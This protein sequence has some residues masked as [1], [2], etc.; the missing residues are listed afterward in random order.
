MKKLLI[1]A[2]IIAALSGSALAQL[3]VASGIVSGTGTSQVISVSPTGIPLPFY[4][5]L[6]W[7]TV[8]APVG[9]CGIA[10]DSSITGSPTPEAGVPAQ[11]CATT[12]SATSASAVVSNLIAVHWSM[13]GAGSIFYTVTESLT[14]PASGS[15]TITA[16]NAGTGITGGGV[17]GS[18]NVAIAASYRLPQS[19]S[20]GQVAT[21]DSTTSAWDTCASAAGTIT[22]V[23]A[24]TGLSGGGV[25]GAVTLNLNAT[26]TTCSSQVLTAINSSAVG[27]CTPLT[28]SYL[29]LSAMGT[30]TGGTWQGSVIGSTYGGT[31]VNNT[32]T[33]T[34]GSVNVN[35]ATLGTGLVYNTTGTGALT[36][37]NAA[38]VVTVIGSTAVTNATN[39]ANIATT[40]GSASGATFYPVFVGSNS[41]SNQGV[42]TTAALNFVPST[43]VLSATSFSGAGTNLTGTAS[44]LSIGGNAA[45]ATTA[46]NATNVA[47]TGGSASSSTFYPT[48][49]SSNSSGNYPIITTGALSFVPST[50]ALSATSFSG[51]G[52]GLTGT[53][54][55][56]SIGGNA[57]TA[58]GINGNGTA[59]QVWGMNSGGSAQ[60]WQNQSGTPLG[61]STQ[62]PIMNSGATAYAPQTISQDASLSNSGVLTV[63]GINAVPLCTGFTPTAGQALE[64]STSLSPNPCYTAATPGG[65]LSG[66]LGEPYVAPNSG[67]S[68]VTSPLYLDVSQV[69]GATGDAI[70][71]GATAYLITAGGGTGDTRAIPTESLTSLTQLTD[72]LAPPAVA[73]TGTSPCSSGT[74]QAKIVYTYSSAGCGGE[75]TQ[76]ASQETLVSS[77]STSQKITVTAPTYTGS[78]TGWNVYMAIASGSAP[79]SWTETKCNTTALT[80]GVNYDITAACSGAAVNLKNYNLAWILPVDGAWTCTMTAGTSDCIDIGNHTDIEGSVTGS[81]SIFKIQAASTTNVASSGVTGVPGALFGTSPNPKLGVGSIYIRVVGLSVWDQQTAAVV[82]STIRIGNTSDSSVVRDVSEINAYQSSNSGGPYGDGGCGIWA[83]GVGYADWQNIHVDGNNSTGEYGFCLGAPGAGQTVLNIDS[84]VSV[85]TSGPN[86]YYYGGQNDLNIQ[87]LTEEGETAVSGCSNVMNDF[88]AG[89]TQNGAVHIGT[90]KIGANCTSSTATAIKLESNAN[91]IDIDRISIGGATGMTCITNNVSG[92]PTTPLTQSQCDSVAT[93]PAA[94]YHISRTPPIFAAGLSSGK[95][96][97][98]NGNPFLTSANT[99]SAVDSVTI[100]NAATANPATVTITASGSDANINLN[101]VSTGTGPVQ[102]NGSSGANTALSNL[103]SVAVNLALSPGTDNSIALDDLSHRYTNA[104]LAGVFGWTNGSGTADTGL[105]RDSAGVVDVGNGTASDTSGTLQATKLTLTGSTHG[106]TIPA[107][108][109]VSGAAGKVIFASD[110]TNGYAEANENNTGLSRICTAANG[111]CPSGTTTNALTGAVSG[112]ASPGTTFNGSAAV[113]FDY[114]TLGAAPTASPTFTGTVTTPLTTAGL[115]TTTSGGVLGSEAQATAAQ[116]GTGISTSSSTGVPSISSG[117]WSVGN[118]P[119][120]NI[121]TGI[122]IGSIGSS[123]LSGTAPVTISAAGA[124]ACVTCVTSAASLS[125]NAI[126]TGAGSQAS[127]TVGDFTIGSTAHTLLGGASALFDMSAATGAN[128]L[129]IPSQAGLTSN[130]TS[131]I[132][133]DTTGK[134]FHIPTNG[135]DS[136]AVAE[137]GTSTT[138]TQ[139]LH[140]TSVAG[141]GSFSAIATGDLPTG[142]PIGNI[143]TSGLSGTL[144]ISISAAGAISVA[145][146]NATYFPFQSLTTTGSGAASLSAGVLNIPTPVSGV[147][148]VSNSDGTLTISPTTGAVVASL[149]TAHANTFSANQTMNGYLITGEA[150]KT[151]SY[152]G[153][154]TADSGNVIVMNCSSACTYTLNGSPTAGYY[155]WVLSVGSTVATVSLN[156]KN[157]NGATSVPVLNS[158]RPWFFTS[159]GTNYFG[160]APLVAGSNISLTPAS[161]GFTVAI[162]TASIN[163][164]DT[165]L[166][167][168]TGS[169]SA[170]D[171]AIGDA[172]GGVTPAIAIPANVTFP[173][174]GAIGGTTPAAITGTTVTAITSVTAPLIDTTTHCA[175]AGSAANPSVASCSAAPAGFFSCATNASTGTCVV[176]TTAVTANSVIQIQPDSSL[177][178][179]LSVS[180]NTTADSGLTAPRVS[181]RSAGTSFTITLGT[182]STN[183]E[184]FSYII[185]N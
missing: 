129:K 168:A 117:T 150:T 100:G 52:T 120:A 21:W 159:D 106:I 4:Y 134:L 48:F 87:S 92:Y 2:L 41:S 20:N 82:P 128:A 109:A 73:A 29:P 51:A 166:Q 116:G 137:T 175:A 152:T 146:S 164:T 61:S 182:F 114:H 88:A 156:S 22:G 101:L 181:A 149:N 58:T 18:V 24:G 23:T 155:G 131:S 151:S 70:L 95:L 136:T 138:T 6:S 161:N 43:G 96:F 153:N 184:C 65:S 32:A 162:P 158:Y 14:P 108:T 85:H 110:S 123:G 174:P 171:I 17:T 122:P 49:V 183:P 115:V 33:L 99:A 67:L 19:C 31:G 127:Q 1:V 98:A 141:I 38:Q 62:V 64:Y 28:S 112:G 11:N 163:G 86:L 37:A 78:A 40:G 121:P 89:T 13:S 60:G 104:W 102:C 45:T 35:L 173:S 59:N 5:T 16:V 107:G 170:S 63:K 94:G 26:P 44:S 90:F 103:A 79:T 80:L 56:L 83:F 34:L 180:C 177:G 91:Q 50:G 167:S 7:N 66:T 119:V 176:D 47:T 93:G 130:G 77:V 135:A 12:G 148:S 76:N 74:C 3:T 126:M 140:A 75:C 185:M 71:N 179:A 30:I 55:G 111:V 10:V 124:I 39:A 54:A 97:D 72:P 27:T 84:L 154:S 46:T 36:N 145:Y 169:F 157:F 139:V 69:S 143:G 68:G 142:I 118:V 42:V 125:S 57:T 25:S 81:S 9:T 113:T 144:P 160:D 133:Y 8:S 15:G 105:S 178:T 132:A 53:A 147:S 165:K 172:N